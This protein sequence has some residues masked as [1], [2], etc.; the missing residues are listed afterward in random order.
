MREVRGEGL[1]VSIELGPTGRDW[2]SQVSPRL[3]ER[4]AREVF[5][6]WAAVRL[7]EA[8][9]IVQPPSQHWEVVQLEPPLPIA[10]PEVARGIDTVAGVL[11]EYRGVA[12]LVAGVGARLGRQWLAGWSF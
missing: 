12:A 1:L 5:G 2:A 4:V 9:L 8:G 7:L 3:V 6:Q 11:G 10:A